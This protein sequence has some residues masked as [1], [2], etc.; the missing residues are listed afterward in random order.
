VNAAVNPADI[1]SIRIGQKAKVR[2]DAYSNVILDGHVSGIGAIAGQGGGRFRRSGSGLYLKTVPVEITID[3]P[4][5]RVLPDLSASADVSLSSMHADVIIPRAALAKGESE[6]TVV[7]V[8]T[9]D[10]FEPREVELGDHND[11][12]VIVVDGVNE[13]EEVLLSEPP[14]AS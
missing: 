8:R 5:D 2:L 6:A 14:A 13:G 9:T 11:T 4:D 7:Y 10:G 3:T 1:Q 12:H